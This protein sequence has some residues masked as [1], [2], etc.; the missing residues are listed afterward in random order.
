MPQSRGCGEMKKAKKTGTNT[1]TEWRKIAMYES[2]L[3]EKQQ[4]I[5][6]QEDLLR[7]GKKIGNSS[8]KKTTTQPALK[9]N[10]PQRT[11]YQN[12]KERRRRRQNVR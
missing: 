1:S 11:D 9:E 4:R 10:I 2:Y 5:V 7:D 6:F 3:K 8:H 12:S